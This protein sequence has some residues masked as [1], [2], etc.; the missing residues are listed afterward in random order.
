MISTKTSIS[1]TKMDNSYLFLGGM[2]ASTSTPLII[3]SIG[4]KNES[5]LKFMLLAYVFHFH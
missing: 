3:K 2:K 5:K 4:L 1:L